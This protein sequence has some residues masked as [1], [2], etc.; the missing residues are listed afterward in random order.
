MARLTAVPDAALRDGVYVR[1][2]AIMGRAD[3]RFLS[4][5]IQRESIDR[6]RSRGPRSRVVAQWDDIDVSTA[7]TPLAK[8]PGLQA[9]L[10]AARDGS[11]DRLWILTL[12]R[13]DR[14]TAA[15]KAFDEISAAGVELWTEA[16]R[17]DLDSPEGYLSTSMQLVI[18]RYQRDRIGKAWRQTHEHRLE[19]GLPHTGKPKFG[20]VYDPAQ[21]LHIVDPINGP[22]LAACYQRY[23]DGE[24]VYALVRWL[25]ASSITTT[26]GGMWSDRVLR[27]VM[28]AGFAAGVIT[29]NNMVREGVHEHLISAELWAQFQACRGLRRVQVNTERSQ[30][31]LSGL[32]RCGHCGGAMVAGQYGANHEPK[33]RCKIGKETGVHTGGYVMARFVEGAVLEWLRSIAYDVD[34]AVHLTAAVDLCAART[35]R[36]VAAMRKRETQLAEQLQV[37]AV[38]VAEGLFTDAEYLAAARQL[39]AER[40]RLAEEVVVAEREVARP[41]VGNPTGVAAALLTDWDELPVPARREVLRRLIARV[42]VTSGRPRGVVRIVSTWE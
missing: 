6:A 34:Q 9:A 3:D 7:K 37:L 23:V 11:I 26:S 31:V 17:V 35:R 29:Y 33:Y 2:S 19:Q 21:R 25:N 20:Y 8:R 38:K 27:R 39:R 42:E 18:A 16:G 22:A 5:D 14:D 15:L 10:T 13:F 32:V 12:D 1:V 24:S 30:Y 28:D 40:T 36:D 41:K 4:P